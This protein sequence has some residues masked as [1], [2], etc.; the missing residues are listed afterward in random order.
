MKMRPYQEEAVA[1]IIK[2]FREVKSTLIVMATGLGKT[3]VFT[4]LLDLAKKGRVLVVAH[5]EELVDQAAKKI[6]TITG[7][8]PAIEMADRVSNESVFESPQGILAR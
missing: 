6:K 4:H 3:I 1:A 5:R 7:E 8:Y 2:E